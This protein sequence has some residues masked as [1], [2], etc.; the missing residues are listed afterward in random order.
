MSPE[1]QI[2]LATSE[3]LTDDHEFIKS[4][5]GGN[6]LRRQL[7]EHRERRR[8]PRLGEPAPAVLTFGHMLDGCPDH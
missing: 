2:K 1:E 7:E 8:W 5:G 6:F 3:L 4:L